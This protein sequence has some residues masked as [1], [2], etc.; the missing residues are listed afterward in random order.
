MKSTLRFLKINILPLI[1]WLLAIISVFLVPL[2]KEYLKYF[3]IKTLVCLLSIMLI[4]GAYKNIRIF[5]IAA[6]SLIKKL[7]NTRS[8]VFSLVFLTYFFSIFIANDMALLTF[9]PLTIAV[10]TVCK[11]EKYIA[12]TIIMQNIAANLGGMIM[13]FGNPQSLYLYSYFN[14][15]IGEFV[16]IMAPPFALSFALIFLFCL[17]VKKE[18]VEHADNPVRELNKPRTV[19]YALFAVIALL[20]VFR[21]INFYLATAIVVVGILICDYKAYAKVDY[22]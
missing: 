11:K 16:A 12:F 9:L 14:I 3:D 5:T 17:F 7:K 4:I 18:S 2:D 6:Q 15:P 21:V 19:I 8:I 1:A 10:F 13:P 20:A 22:A